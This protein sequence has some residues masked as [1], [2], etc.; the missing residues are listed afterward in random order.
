MV[1]TSTVSFAAQ[2][3]RVQAGGYLTTFLPLDI[4]QL[5][6]EWVNTAVLTC[7]SRSY[8]QEEIQDNKL[9]MN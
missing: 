2:L 8:S 5:L 4:T 1:N 6:R 7:P 9:I 3:N